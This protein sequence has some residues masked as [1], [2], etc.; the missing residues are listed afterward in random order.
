MSSCKPGNFDSEAVRRATIEIS[1]IVAP[2]SLS[3]QFILAFQGRMAR[4]FMKLALHVP[5][6]RLGACSTRSLAD[7]LPGCNHAQAGTI[8][9]LGV[10]K[11]LDRTWFSPFNSLIA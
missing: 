10:A 2:L 11:K 8:N 1:L 7:S 6:T 3:F 5:W 4:D 9:F